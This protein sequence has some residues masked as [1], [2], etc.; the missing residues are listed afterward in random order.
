MGEGTG[1]SGLE[2][3]GAGGRESLCLPG[4]LGGSLHKVVWPTEAMG[5]L[6]GLLSL[7]GDATCGVG[8]AVQKGREGLRGIGES[9]PG[10]LC[11]R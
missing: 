8:M 6:V 2:Q 1:E 9:Q 5:Q 3:E 11:F 7:L 10:G 4:V